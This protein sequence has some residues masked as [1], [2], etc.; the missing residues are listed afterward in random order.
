MLA[1]PEDK[2]MKIRQ[3]EEKLTLKAMFRIRGYPVG[4]DD[5]MMSFAQKQLTF[6]PFN[7]KSPTG[8]VRILKEIFRL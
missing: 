6:I 2:S 4:L 3:L 8:L 7:I 1:K 5:R